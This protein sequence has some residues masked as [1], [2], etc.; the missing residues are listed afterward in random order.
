LRKE[1]FIWHGFSICACSRFF[2]VQV[3]PARKFGLDRKLFSLK[4]KVAAGEFAHYA[5]GVGGA[6]AAS[7]AVDFARK[8]EPAC[9]K[10]QLFSHDGITGESCSFVLTSFF[11]TTKKS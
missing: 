1:S 2:F 8:P 9:L 10:Y 4:I 3:I 5:G 7:K 6:F 11:L